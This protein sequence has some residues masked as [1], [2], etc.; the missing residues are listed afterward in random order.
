MKNLLVSLG[1]TIE[2]TKPSELKRGELGIVTQSGAFRNT[3]TGLAA[4]TIYKYVVGL[5]DGKWISGLWLKSPITPIKSAY[6]PAD[7]KA[8]T[9]KS[10]EFDLS[11]IADAEL[12]IQC[13]PKTSFAGDAYQEFVAVTS[14]VSTTQTEEAVDAALTKRLIKLVAEINKYYDKTVI[15]LP[16]STPT[17]L[18][19]LVL[20][21]GDTDFNFYVNFGGATSG[22]TEETNALTFGTLAEVIKLEKDMAIA[23]FGYNPNFEATDE[24]Y[25]NVLLAGYALQAYNEAHSGDKKAG[26]DIYVLSSIVPATD[27]M[28]LHPDGARVEQWIALPNGVTLA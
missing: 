19:D 6:D 7:K 17:T 1:M 8:V 12:H 27:Q 2:A 18:K 4:D 14:I 23:T 15:E 16:E 20:T 22:V 26:Y 3:S 25:G 9:I 21:A 24:A 28:A 13:T 10:V 5:G 11:G